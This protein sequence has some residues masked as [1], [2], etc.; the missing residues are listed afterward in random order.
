MGPGVFD[1]VNVTKSPQWVTCSVHSVLQDFDITV[2][3]FYGYNTPSARQEMW[4]YIKGS[5]G[6]HKDQPWVLM[7]DFNATMEPIDSA[8]GDTSWSSQKQEFSLCLH[9]A[10]IHMVPYRGIKYN[11]HNGQEGENTILKK[12]DWVFG[13][14]TLATP[15]PNAVAHFSP[16]S[17]SDHSSMLLQLRK[18]H[19]KPRPSFKFLNFWAEREDFIPQITRVWQM[20]IQGS[21]M[22]RLTSKLQMVKACLKNWHKVNKSHISSR[23]IKAKADW[24]EAQED[25]EQDY[26]PRGWRGKHYSQPRGLGKSGSGLL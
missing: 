17:V 24:D 12:L 5:G 3:F 10:E 13:N 20:H 6:I 25:E 11:L 21:P 14:T 2:S 23:V 22:F 16:R 19:L 26:W 18:D 15:W 9:Q 4:E 8:G 1:V 7:G